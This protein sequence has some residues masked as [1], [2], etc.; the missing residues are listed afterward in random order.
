MNYHCVLFYRYEYEYAKLNS[1]HC[2]LQAILTTTEQSYTGTKLE[3]QHVSSKLARLEKTKGDLSNR[4]SI[5]TE[6]MKLINQSCEQQ[7]QDI[8]TYKQK[9]GNLEKERSDLS[10]N[11][12]TLQQ[13]THSKG[14]AYSAKISQLQTTLNS[15]KIEK[16][17]LENKISVLEVT[18]E[19]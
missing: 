19:N 2:R 8:S 9:I 18:L 6:K 12:S 7:E 13:S 10:V 15:L 17:T 1:E 14:Q 5:L 4:F 3:L 11:L 16:E